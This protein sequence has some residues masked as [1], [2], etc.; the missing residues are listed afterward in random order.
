MIELSCHPSTP[1]DAVRAVAVRVSRSAG[2][3][4]VL[5]FHLDGELSLI[6]VPAPRPPR[7][8]HQLWEHTC[9]EAFI[10]ADDAVAYHELNF[11]P[12][13]EWAG[14]AFRS[15][16]E[17]AGIADEALAPRIAVRT[18]ADRFELEASLAL[19]RLSPP[20]RHA[21]LRLGLSAVIEEID[22]ERSYWSLRHPSPQPDFHHAGALAL[23][24][25]P[26]GGEW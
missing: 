25:E 10:A 7:L 8:T 23:R 3:R 15:Y 21:T 1:T 24:L 13:G 9:F 26:A 18:A 4:L 2:G 22:G 11:S 19:E 14:Y 5:T 20:Y 17:I 6:D 16:R 12:S